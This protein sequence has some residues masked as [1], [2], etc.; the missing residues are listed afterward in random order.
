TGGRALMRRAPDMNSLVALG[1]G[2]AWL[3]SM[4]VLLIPDAL[5]ATARA[6]YFEAAAVI[7][8]LILTGRWLEARAKGQTGAAIA[9][10]VGLRPDQALVLHDGQP[11]AVDAAVLQPGDTVLVRPGA[12]VPTDG[13]VVAGRSPVDESMLTGEPLPVVKTPGDGVTGGTVNGAGAL[14]LRVTHVGNDTALARII[15]MVTQA[16]AARLPIQALVDRVTLWFV[17]AVL[18]LALCT[19]MIWVLVG[20]SVAQAL[21]AAVSV[22]II[23]CPCAM[24]LATPT[25]IMVGSGRAAELG[26]MFRKGEALQS[27]AEV[28]VIALD[29]TGTLTK[30]RPAVTDL[31]AAVGQ[32]AEQVLT[33]AASVE[34]ASEHPLGA[35]IV[36]AAADR[37]QSILPPAQG[38]TPTPGQGVCATVDGHVIAIG[39]PRLLG[40]DGVRGSD[41]DLRAFADQLGQAGRTVLYVCV[42]GAVALVLGVADPIKPSSPAAVA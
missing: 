6:V 42:D 21:V 41:A 28:D 29:K 2:A 7:V 26:V 25:S 18:I 3:F 15:A 8:T 5:P 11:T 17:P 32:D 36:Q 22:L 23:A 37:G 10:L 33:W 19:G 24:G 9:A 39:G 38:F 34:A 4:T 13:L 16:Q 35:A 31:R 40:S 1:A 14:T 12:R 30:G 27:L 20:P